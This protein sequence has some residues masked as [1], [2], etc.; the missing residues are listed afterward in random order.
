MY[1]FLRKYA[2]K[3]FKEDCLLLF[4]KSIKTYKRFK[5]L[6]RVS[7]KSPGKSPRSNIC[8]YDSIFNRIFLI[9]DENALYP[10]DYFSPLTLNIAIFYSVLYYNRE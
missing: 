3:L 5:S 2:G 8:N 7:I 9:L 1:I 4:P 10:M 6:T